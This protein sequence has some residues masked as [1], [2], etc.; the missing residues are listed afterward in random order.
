MHQVSNRL[1]AR[2][3]AIPARSFL[4]RAVLDQPP[5]IV[6]RPITLLVTDDFFFPNFSEEA[7]LFKEYPYLQEVYVQAV[8]SKPITETTEW[9][10]V[11][12]YKSEA[13]A[14]YL[15]G[16]FYS[17]VIEYI[18]MLAEECDSDEEIRKY[19][20]FGDAYATSAEEL[21]WATDALVIRLCKLEDSLAN[22][23]PDSG[24][25][26]RWLARC[27]TMVRIADDWCTT[28]TLALG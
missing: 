26:G 12:E 10:A 16:T 22:R 14:D 24:Y 4:E 28:D 23:H 17:L 3:H 7:S 13:V 21:Y 20:E 15:M 27:S 25:L 18:E 19:E 8:F 1:L 5:D 11:V 2:K 6:G 9:G